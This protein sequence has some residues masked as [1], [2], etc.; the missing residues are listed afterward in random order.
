MTDEPSPTGQPTREDA[1]DVTRLL[2][3][4]AA[5]TTGAADRLASRVYEELH[6]IAVAA[7]RREDDGHT[8]QPT[9]LVHEAFSRLLLE[10]L[11]T[12]K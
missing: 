12:S 7:M 2:V 8:W 11:T 10:A 3:D 1:S 4:L 6:V 9:E 5:G